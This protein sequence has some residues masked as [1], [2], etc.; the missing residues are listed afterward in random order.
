M[1]SLNSSRISYLDGV[2]FKRVVVAAAGRLIENS[3]HLDSINVFP[4]PDGDTG[5]NMAGTMKNIVH[6][7]GDSLERSIEKM[8][9]IIAESALDGAR[10][11]SGAILAQFL[12]GFAEGVKNLRKISMEDFASA[13]SLAAKRSTEAISDPREGTILSVIKEWASHLKDNCKS[14]QDFP[15]LLYDSLE[16]ARGSVKSTTE[17]LAD[18]KAAGVVDAGALGFV[19]LLEGIVDFLE[20]G[21]IAKKNIDIFGKAEPMGVAQARVAVDSLEFRFCT[22]YLLKGQDIDRKAIRKAVSGMGD[23]L[24]VAGL[25]ECVKVHIHTNEPDKVGEILSSYGR[26]DKKK[27]DDMLVQH[28]RILADT[29]TVGIV[30]DSTCDLPKEILDEYDIRIAPLRL[31]LDDKEYIDQVD[32]TSGEFYEKLVTSDKALTSQPVPG[33][34]KRVYSSV[35]SDYDSVVSVHIAGALSGTCRAAQTAVSGVENIEIVDGANVTV[36]LGLIVL[37]AAKAAKK[38][39]SMAEVARVAKKAAENVTIYVAL[40]TLEYVVK[41][42]RMSKGQGLAAKILNIKPIIT[43]DHEGRVST[44]AK[45][46]GRE[47]QKRTLINLV[48]ERVYGHA[49]LRYAVAHAA[50]PEV[51]ADFS[52]VLH[53]EFGA[54]PEFISEASPAIGIHSGPRAFAIAVL[55]DD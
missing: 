36:A 21:K 11:N 27:V 18:L 47:R 38:G 33:D 8:S 55:T 50:A 25:P 39:L 53:K 23:S 52:K 6:S 4:V 42:G 26:I 2:R 41:G 12:C 34:M 3:P 16:H 19:Y 48:R 17:K 43:F 15:E 46:I 49:N 37:E 45:V 44:V 31:T 54:S 35:A 10:G 51:A 5:A 28:R 13:A 14:Y 29:R 20:N 1:E 32:I 30:S 24:I 9:A 22:E 7:T 40:D